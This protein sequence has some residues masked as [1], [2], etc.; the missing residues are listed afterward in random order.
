M[1]L[2]LPICFGLKYN[3]SPGTNLTFEVMHRFTS[4]DYLDD[5]STTYAGADAFPLQPNGQPSPAFL[6]Q[7][8]SYAITPIPIG[9]AGRQRGNSLRKDQYITATIGITINLMSYKCPSY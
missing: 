1:A 5:V 9:I 6:L 4:T 3:I 2:V 8:R 7:D